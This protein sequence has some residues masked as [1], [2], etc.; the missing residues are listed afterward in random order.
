MLNSKIRPRAVVGYGIKIFHPS[1]PNNIT[2][3]PGSYWC[4]FMSKGRK[5]KRQ[6]DKVALLSFGYLWIPLVLEVK[7]LSWG[8]GRFGFCKNVESHKSVNSIPQNITSRM[9]FE[10]S[11]LS[12]PSL[13]RRKSERKRRMM[14]RFE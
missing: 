4:L 12:H 11:V 7:P 3:S 13:R 14:R 2:R 9:L 8:W 6:I 10:C 1:P 5:K